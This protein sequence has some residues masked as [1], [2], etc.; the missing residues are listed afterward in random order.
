MLK[1]FKTRLGIKQ[2]NMI[3]WNSGE[4]P[5][6]V[7]KYRDWKNEYHRK[8]LLHQELFIPSPRAFNDPFDCRLQI[9]YHLL[10]D[11]DKLATEYCNLVVNRHFP[12]FSEEQHD[13]EVRRLLIEGR[14]KNEEYI[15]SE[16]QKSIEK[17]H[18]TF[19]VFSV[20]AVNDNILMWA[21]YSNDHQGFCVGFDSAQLFSYIGGAG[22]EV[23][24]EEKYPTILPTEDLIIQMMKQTY[25]KASFWDYEIEYRLSK[26]EFANKTIIIPKEIITEVILGCKIS[27]SDEKDILKIISLELPHVKIFKT[28]PRELDFEFDIVK[29]E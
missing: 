5:E 4:I 2:I 17:L 28:K 19:G 18:D 1:E 9:A 10:K 6:K 7:Y 20:T 11:D 29:I 16:N 25:T 3:S 27:E 21:H 14:L 23:N 24:Y 13:Q 22:C 26:M 15:K 12:K 8:I